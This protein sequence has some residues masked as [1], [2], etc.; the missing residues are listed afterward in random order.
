MRSLQHGN[1][2]VAA[3]FWGCHPR[4]V[5][6]LSGVG[7]WFLGDCSQGGICQVHLAYNQRDSKVVASLHYFMRS[8]YADYLRS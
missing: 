2:T 1:M 6:L 8:V 3:E 5:D 7:G 4:R